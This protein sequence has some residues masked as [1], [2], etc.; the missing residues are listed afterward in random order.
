MVFLCFVYQ[1]QF[2][3]LESTLPVGQSLSS[4]YC[5][6]QC[7]AYSRSS[8]NIFLKEEMNNSHYYHPWEAWFYFLSPFY[9]CENRA[10]EKWSKVPV[11]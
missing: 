4:V 7:L 3:T 5:L 2:L 10:L 9:R 1:R 11:L 6:G 8:L